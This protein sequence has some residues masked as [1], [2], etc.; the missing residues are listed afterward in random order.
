[1]ILELESLMADVDNAQRALDAKRRLR[2]NAEADMAVSMLRP[3]LQERCKY[4]RS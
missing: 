4:C 1:M 2:D 3:S